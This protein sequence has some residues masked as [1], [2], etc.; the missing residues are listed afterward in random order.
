MRRI[1]ATLIAW[2]PDSLL[3]AVL[4]LLERFRP[5][6]TSRSPLVMC[7]VTPGRGAATIPAP[8]FLKIATG[9][10]APAG[11][12]DTLRSAGIRVTDATWRSTFAGKAA[13]SA[14]VL[15]DAAGSAIGT[16]GTTPLSAADGV[17]LLTWVGI[18]AEHQGRGLAKPLVIAALHAAA[19]NGMKT[20]FLLTDDH[21]LPAI[22]TY[23]STG[24]R[25]CPHS[26]DWMQRPRWRRIARQLGMTLEACD[27]DSHTQWA[28]RVPDEVD[29]ATD[30][31]RV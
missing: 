1:K 24:F 19:A 29:P 13:A 21:R 15:T 5:E 14:A 12:I 3:G 22:R 20:V 30:V 17:A 26:W 4:P 2:T 23:L 7:C 28:G 10:T 31:R 9:P 18:H 11:W 27:R 16:A 6:V 25:P 8:Y